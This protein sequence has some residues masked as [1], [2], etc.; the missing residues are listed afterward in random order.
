MATTDVTILG[1][2]ARFGG[3]QEPQ[4]L[5]ADRTE[6]TGGNSLPRDGKSFPTYCRMGREPLQGNYTPLIPPL[7]GV[8]TITKI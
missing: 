3:G 1:E 7:T 6:L 2:A 5:I 8:F 4:A